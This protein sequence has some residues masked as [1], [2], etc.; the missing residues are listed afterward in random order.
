VS[1]LHTVSVRTFPPP[2]ASVTYSFVFGSC[3]HKGWTGTPKNYAAVLPD[4]TDQLSADFRGFRRMSQLNPAFLLFLGDFIY[5]ENPFDQGRDLGDYNKRYRR[6]LDDPSA[7]K[8]LE[9]T[10]SFFMFD[11]HEIFNDFP[12][13]EFDGREYHNGIRIS[14]QN[15]LGLTNPPPL[16]PF[17]FYYNYTYGNSAFFVVDTR[18]FRNRDTGTML[19]QEQKLQLFQWLLDTNGLFPFRFIASSVSFSAHNGHD[20]WTAF[21]A[22][23]NEIINFLIANQM[24]GVVLLSGDLHYALVTQ[25]VPGLYEFSASPIDAFPFFGVGSQPPYL[26]P[27]LLHRVWR[28]YITFFQ[29]TL[30][31]RKFTHVPDIVILED[32]SLIRPMA[33]WRDK[34]SISR[35]ERHQNTG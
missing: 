10:P 29:V 9:K 30:M 23:R 35:S 19:G 3:I 28:S 11:D 32:L 27:R 7:R 18:T 20:S 17:G 25:I 22:E 6:H 4:Q 31:E 5:I 8:F 26:S 1:A 24:N 13:T 12:G 14:W 21:R 2:D 33:S 16:V 34:F 15:Y